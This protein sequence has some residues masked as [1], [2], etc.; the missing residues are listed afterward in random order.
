[1]PLEIGTFKP[2]YKNPHPYFNGQ[3]LGNWNATQ[4]IYLKAKFSLVNNYISI[5]ITRKTRSTSKKSLFT[6][7]IYA[8]LQVPDNYRFSDIDILATKT[9]KD[10]MSSTRINY[11][12]VKRKTTQHI[13]F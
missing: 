4:E 9:K 8:H 13:I 5:I 12:Q 10:T 7:T 6:K 1:M 2:F 11:I 3:M